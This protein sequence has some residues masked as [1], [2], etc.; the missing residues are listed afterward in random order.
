M[1]PV[2]I[3]HPL[4]DKNLSRWETLRTVLEGEDAVKKAGEKYLP[5]LDGQ[6]YFSDYPGAAGAN[7]TSYSAYKDRASFFDATSR[8]RDALVGAVLRKESEIHFPER[9]R[10]RLNTIGRDGESFGEMVQEALDEVIGMGRFGHLIDAP[11]EPDGDPFVASYQA[12]NITDWDEIIVNG[13]KRLARVVLREVSDGYSKDGKKQ[14]V[15]NYRI[16][17]LGY[18]SP[19]ND[20]VDAINKSTLTYFDYFGLS[21]D[22]LRDG[23]IY[24]QEIWRPVDDAKD[25]KWYLAQIIIPR[26]RGGVPLNEIPFIFFNSSSTKPKPQKSPLYDLSAVNLSHYR[27]S[28]DLEH[29]LHFT[30]L[31]Q[32]WAAGFKMDSHAVLYI[33]SGVAWVTEE[34][35]GHAG[36]LEFTGAGLRAISDRMN[37]KKKEMALLGA[38]LLDEPPPSGGNEAAETIKLRQAGERSVLAKLTFSVS[39][40]LTKSLRYIAK[41]LGI[42]NIENISIAL[43]TDFGVEGLSPTMLNA[44]MAQVQ[45][46]VMSWNT[47]FWNLKRGEVIPDG[48][49]EEAEAERI[50]AGIPGQEAME[51]LLKLKEGEESEEDKEDEDDTE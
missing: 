11:Q 38:R 47:Y 30:A 35:G 23:A 19:P 27:N 44:L 51:G 26:I 50:L 1:P 36:Y 45:T 37:D 17:R 20:V 33:G 25:E 28:A 41:W 32:P 5:R 9:E 6:S 12:E 29:G 21:E 7:V 24:F 46:G 22:D 34:P 8:T 40:G 16:L 43:N 4:Y 48:I 10:V 49:D 42:N 2:T 13:R 39:E 14:P 31:P 18:P 15:I 3:T